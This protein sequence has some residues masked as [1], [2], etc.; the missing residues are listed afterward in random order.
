LKKKLACLCNHILVFFSFTIQKPKLNSMKR[1]ITLFGLLLILGNIYCQ[2][3]SLSVKP[4]QFSVIYPL[5]TAGPASIDKAYLVSLNMLAGVTGAAKGLEIGGISNVN[6]YYNQGIQLAGISNISGTTNTGVQ[7]AGINNITGSWS[8]GAQFAGICNITGGYVKGGQFSGIAN[9]SGGGLKGIQGA[10]IVNITDGNSTGIQ[11]AGI[12]NAAD[13]INGLQAGGIINIAG[14][15][16]A[17]QLAGIGN[18]AD[19]VDG[20]QIGGIFNIADNVKGV[21]LAGIINICDSIDGIPIALISIVGKNGYRR[22]DISANETFY[23]NLTYKIGIRE[24][25]TMFTLG[26]RPGEES[27]NTGLGFGIGTNKTIGKRSG[28]E[29]EV[30]SYQISRY[31]W[32]DEDNSMY[33]IRMHYVYNF[34][35]RFALFAGPSYNFMHAA[36]TSDADEIAPSWAGNHYTSAYNWSSWI[37]F[38]AGVRF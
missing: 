25:Y 30:H 4:F 33:T 13:S 32:M 18:I 2:Q 21:Q 38:N 31:L 9:V 14:D 11:L 36:Q 7:I 37:G 12:G 20:A 28:I 19:E 1:N 29:L 27:N 5:S 15:A 6:K 3:D 23:V 8:K 17:A 22:W 16:K 10:G 26:Y 35:E 24:L 34:G